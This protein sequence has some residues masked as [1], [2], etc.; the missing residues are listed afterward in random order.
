[1]I[2]T[3]DTAAIDRTIELCRNREWQFTSECAEKAARKLREYA[4]EFIEPESFSDFLAL[5]ADK[6]DSAR[7][8]VAQLG[9]DR[10]GQKVVAI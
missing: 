2:T 10:K 1:M 6:I 8:V 7:R 9:E 5:A 3:I 4:I